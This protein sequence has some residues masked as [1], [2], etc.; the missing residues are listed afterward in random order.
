MPLN[1]WTELFQI[2]CLSPSLNS[3]FFYIYIPICFCKYTYRN[4]LTLPPL[5]QDGPQ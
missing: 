1:L 4:I 2:L 3:V 5:G